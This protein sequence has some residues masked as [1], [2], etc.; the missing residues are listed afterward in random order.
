MENIKPIAVY[1]AM[2][3]SE[4]KLLLD[5]RS[6]FPITSKFI[7]KKIAKKLAKIREKLNEINI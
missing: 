5:M 2:K 6:S 7:D 1:V 3:G 4:I